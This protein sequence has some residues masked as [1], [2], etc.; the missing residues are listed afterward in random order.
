MITIDGTAARLVVGGKESGDSLFLY[1]SYARG[2]YDATSDIDILRI[3]TH[4]ARGE[5]MH[6]QVSIHTYDIKDLIAMANQGSLFILHLLREA[7]PLQNP[8]EFL[9]ELRNAFVAPKS[10]A[11]D[12]KAALTPAIPLLNISEPLF[13]RSPQT[14]MS[15]AVFLCRTLVYAEH[16]DR[17]PFSFSL[18]SLAEKD[19]TASI[20]WGIKNRSISY[21]DFRSLREIV[22]SKLLL[23]S[24]GAEVVSIKELAARSKGDPLFDSLLRRI[25][26]GLRNTPYPVATNI[27]LQGNRNSGVAAAAA[28][29]RGR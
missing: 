23:N 8:R 1:G 28:P 13:Q 20:L 17:G 16:A 10:Y 22:R 18:K 2:D 21:S 25:V 7:R 24:V 14:F 29:E 26:S 9:S 11:S 6:E 3:A 5:R 4:R 19:E 15:T 12:A 27:A